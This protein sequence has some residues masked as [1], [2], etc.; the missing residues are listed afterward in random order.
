MNQLILNVLGDV[1][2]H[3]RSCAHHSRY[4]C[5]NGIENSMKVM[6]KGKSDVAVFL[7]KR[8]KSLFKRSENTTC[9]YQHGLD[10]SIY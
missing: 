9:K 2:D 1:G 8:C 7:E 4:F 6:S 3:F 5:R 10:I